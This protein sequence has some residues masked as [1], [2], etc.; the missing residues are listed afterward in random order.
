MIAGIATLLL[1]P[2][3]GP[4]RRGTGAHASVVS[5]EFLLGPENA[6]LRHGI[7]CLESQPASLEFCC[8]PLLVYGPT[9]CGKTQ[10][11]EGLA[12]TWSQQ[13]PSDHVLLTPASDFARSYA[14]AVK[15]DDV[16]RF[17]Q[18]FQRASLLL[19][20]GL[21]ALE[22]KAPAQQQLATIID[23]RVRTER[24][25]LL[26][27]QQPLPAQKLSQHL[28][29]RLA[30]GLCVPL[31]SPGMETRREI[32]R[33]LAQQRP[34]RLSAEAEQFLI[35][36]PSLTLVQW[37]GILSRLVA[38]SQDR[39]ASESRPLD[40]LQVRLLTG[41]TDAPAVDP[42]IIIRTTAKHFGLQVRNLTGASRRKL[43]VLARSLAMYL[44]RE[45]TR[46]SF[47][48]IGRHFGDRDHTTV[49]HA[50]RKIQLAQH[51]D[52]EIRA[53]TVQLQRRLSAHK[54]PLPATDEDATT[55]PACG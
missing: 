43:D 5:R 46:E 14:T 48:E 24:P 2:L 53:D 9:G 25:I 34:L 27:A 20:D 10:L 41:E 11:L 33:R 47:Q 32:L 28:V 30:G 38:A 22:S 23:H 51:S 45:L 13:R 17:Q 36:Q 42:K 54:T 49:M 26:T 1:E 15:L 6:L 52:A 3:P 21:E 7:G 8:N 4:G 50:F 12:T 18:R 55:Q 29:S 44:I 19:L 16:V 35:E 40:L 37:L 31:L 39:D